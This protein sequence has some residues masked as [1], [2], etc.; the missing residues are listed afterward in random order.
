LLEHSGV[1]APNRAIHDWPLRAAR[2]RARH[3][4]RHS[5]M[6]NRQIGA[7]L[8]NVS[9]RLSHEIWDLGGITDV[10]HIDIADRRRDRLYINADRIVVTRYQLEQRLSNLAE[11]GNDNL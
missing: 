4:D 5:A 3:T 10:Q 2:D 7:K 8:L 9:S 6:D 1:L 11:T